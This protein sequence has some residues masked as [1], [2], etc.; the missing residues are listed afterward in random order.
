MVLLNYLDELEKQNEDLLIKN[1]KHSKLIESL[2]E[3]NYCYKLL[4]DDLKLKFQQSKKNCE[5]LLN[6]VNLIK[7]MDKIDLTPIQMMREELSRQI[8]YYQEKL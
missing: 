4:N 8:Q 2:E 7:Q 6:Q 5:N 1:E 3:E